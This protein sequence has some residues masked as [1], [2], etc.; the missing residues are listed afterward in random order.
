MILSALNQYYERLRTRTPSPVPAYGFSE[1][2]IAYIIVLDKNGVAVDVLP[3][4][5]TSGKKPVAKLTSVPRPE[6]RTSGVKANFLWDKTSYV[7]GVEGNPDTATAKEHP[8]RVTAKTRETFEAFKQLHI[9]VF[10]DS[11]DEGLAAV[12]SFLSR[13]QPED[14]ASLHCASEMIDANVVFKLDGEHQLIHERSAAQAFWAKRLVPDEDSSRGVCLVTGKNAALARLHPAIKGV[15]GGQSSGG[16]IV[17]FNAD[18]YT[19]YGKDQG[20]NAPVSESAAFAYTTALNYLLRR[21]NRQCFSIGDASTVFWAVADDANT[22][23]EAEDWFS[24]LTNTPDDASEQSELRVSVEAL[25]KGKPLSEIKPNLDANTRFYVLGLAPNASRLSIRYWLDTTLGQLAQNMAWHFQDLAMEPLPW[26][27]PPSVWRLLI[28]TAAQSKSENISPQLA[29]EL[30]RA[31]LTGQPYPRM[32]LTQLV[33]RIRADGD[34]NG[35]RIAIMK[36]VLQREF[37]KGF[38]SE[39]I[40]MAL[41]VHNTNVAYR[42]GR[43][44]AVLERIQE[45]ALSRDLNS[46]IV[47]K[48]YGAASSVPFTV[49][50]RLL[51]G[52]QNHLSRLRKDKPGYAVILKRDLGEVMNGLDGE[53][54]KHMSI[55]AQG[56]FA[57]G[58]YHQKQHYFT[59]KEKVETEE[60]VEAQDN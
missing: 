26:R 55:E 22:A 13:W 39:E 12:R 56:R 2:K 15:Y 40:P 23:K 4:L 34:L 24:V 18:A 10:N 45:A 53:F 59:A 38:I 50:P 48:Y 8:W 31:I 3:N 54:P 33:S 37:R 29:G 46:T 42:L 32:M 1:E 58:Y 7:L 14:F 47:D 60:S 5:D 49:F 25:S 19:S 17:S 21:E 27:E 9:Q 16:S 20:N 51:A 41:D 52:C 28:Q 57:I 35:L 6:K 11:D 44:F 30:T 43:L 36:A